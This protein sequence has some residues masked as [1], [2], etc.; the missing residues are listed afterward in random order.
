METTDENSIIGYG[1]VAHDDRTGNT[2]VGYGRV[3]TL[4]QNLLLQRNAL[5]DEGCTQIFLDEGV[6][7]TV[8]PE[9]RPELSKCLA[10]LRPGDTLMVWKLDRLGRNTLDV[11]TFSDKLQKDGVVFKSITEEISTKGPMGRMWFVLLAAIAQMERDVIVERTL[12]GLA[13]A[14]AQGRIGGR[15]K[16]LDMKKVKQARLLYDAGI[17]V[18]EIA[19]TM[20]CGLSTAYRYLAMEKDA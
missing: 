5:E 14:R 1:R 16:S 20:K 10:Y 8:P 4:E 11:L 19:Q 6:S 2:K 12:A 3:S 17:P 13:A 15:P 18:K 9:Q 7:G